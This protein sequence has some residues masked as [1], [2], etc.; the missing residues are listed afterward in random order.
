MWTSTASLPEAAGALA[1]AIGAEAAW[2]AA[3]V[4]R[5]SLPENAFMAIE[6]R[7]ALVVERWFDGAVELPGWRELADDHPRVRIFR[8]V[9]AADPESSEPELTDSA[10]EFKEALFDQR[11]MAIETSPEAH[12]TP[13][14]EWFGELADPR[15]GGAMALMSLSG[16]RSDGSPFLL[17]NPAALGLT[18]TTSAAGAARASAAGAIAVRAWGF[19]WGS[20]RLDTLPTRVGGSALEEALKPPRTAAASYGAL[21][22]IEAPVDPEIELEDGTVLEQESLSGAQTLAA[23][24]R[25]S[26]LVPAGEMRPLV[27]SA[28]CL[29]RDL[30]S[31]GGEPV[32]PTPLKLTRRHDSQSD[33]WEE[34]EGYLQRGRSPR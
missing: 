30:R 1:A 31:P 20:T 29:N 19:S 21:L 24:E 6:W 23:A 22:E 14:S 4:P 7:G 32:R 26:V 10:W 16:A 13:S 15:L 17:R 25:R 28:W 9:P 2:G 5:A 18:L 3:L 8:P 11:P 27:V 34:R 12:R 33:V